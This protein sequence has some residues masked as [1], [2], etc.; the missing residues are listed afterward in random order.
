MK[1]LIADDEMIS[2]AI[3]R[4]IVRSFCP[5]VTELWEAEDGE[6][7][8]RIA[9]EH[10]VDTAIL[11]IEMPGMN[12]LEAARRIIEKNGSCSVIF[13]TAFASF[14]YAKEAVSLGVSEYL[15]KPVTP[16]ELLRILESC[17]NK[18]L[19]KTGTADAGVADTAVVQRMADTEECR[20]DVLSD[21]SGESIVRSGESACRAGEIA[22]RAQS[23]IRLHYMEDFS[24]EE[25]AE[26]FGVSVNY[27]NRMF[28]TESGMSGKEYLICIRLEQAIEYLKDPAFAVRDVGRLVGYEDPNYFT[29]IFKK[30]TGMTPVEYR[31]HV[32]FG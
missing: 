16:E 24:M 23:Y 20:A 22:A 14:Q 1:V 26:Q 29:R 12:G 5:M 13:L 10:R 11:D 6:M 31:N 21:Q 15:V 19:R 27:M 7:A 18:H 30:K 3:V 4:R 32:L 25:L 2:R 8:V 28:R 17:W 9:E